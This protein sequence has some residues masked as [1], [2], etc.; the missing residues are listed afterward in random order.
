MSKKKVAILL[1]QD[2]AKIPKPIENA[3]RINSITAQ[4]ALIL[5][6]KYFFI[7][8]SHYRK[9]FIF[10]PFSHVPNEIIVDVA[11]NRLFLLDISL[12]VGL[13]HHCLLFG[14]YS[15]QI[16][17]E[18]FAELNFDLPLRRFPQIDLRS[19]FFGEVV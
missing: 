11:P 13:Q 19:V 6:P 5:D 15:H 8:Y 10:V 2:T 4:Y 1:S 9:E 3:E 12:I 7:T 17:I 16:R 14:E 18:L